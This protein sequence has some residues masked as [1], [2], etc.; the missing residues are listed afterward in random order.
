MKTGK[1]TKLPNPGSKEAIKRGCTCAVMDN[2]YGRGARG[3]PK[4]F[5]V[6]VD[7]PLHSMERERLFVTN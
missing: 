1:G 4:Q 3:D 2:N 5:W 6:S 7:C